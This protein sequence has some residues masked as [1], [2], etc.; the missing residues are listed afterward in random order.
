[1]YGGVLESPDD[2][3]AADVSPA[4]FRPR[5]F[6]PMKISR[7]LVKSGLRLNYLQSVSQIYT[8]G[9][10]FA[11]VPGLLRLMRSVCITSNWSQ[12]SNTIVGIGVIKS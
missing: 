1:M 6:F 4:V 9:I 7:H 2:L 8:L 10:D 12:Y 5:I 11:N 3:F